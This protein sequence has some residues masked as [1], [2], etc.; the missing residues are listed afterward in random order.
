MQIE[1]I[2]GQGPTFNA[3]RTAC[4]GYTPLFFEDLHGSALKARSEFSA[5]QQPEGDP[6]RLII[7][8]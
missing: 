1:E 8:S 4:G 6:A 2:H 5:L 7:V 3:D